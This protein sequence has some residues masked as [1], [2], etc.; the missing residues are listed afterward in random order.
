MHINDQTSLKMPFTLESG[1]RLDEIYVLYRTLGQ[2]VNLLASPINRISTVIL[3]QMKSYQAVGDELFKRL[4]FLNHPK[5]R[6]CSLFANQF[7]LQ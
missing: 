7:K 1:S 6:R 5:L 3:Q 4:I 2:I